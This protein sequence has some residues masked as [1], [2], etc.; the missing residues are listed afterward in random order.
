[1]G[2]MCKNKKKQD[3]KD[4]QTNKSFDKLY[5]K[6]LQGNLFG[7]TKC[8]GLCKFFLKYLEETKNESFY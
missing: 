1:M 4:L 8:D 5:R 2:L 6:S 3:E 7:K